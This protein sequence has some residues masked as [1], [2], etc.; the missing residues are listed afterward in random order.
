MLNLSKG[1]KI[2]LTKE[3]NNVNVLAKFNLK[4]SRNY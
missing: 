1:G 2:N 4:D 3:A